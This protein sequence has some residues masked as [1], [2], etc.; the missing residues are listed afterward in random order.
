M[1]INPSISS[2]VA[3][4]RQQEMAAQASQRRLAA[5]LSAASRASRPDRRAGRK[6]GRRVLSIRAQWRRAVG[7]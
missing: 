3:R 2:E 1:F 6:L 4:H 5:Q 7:F